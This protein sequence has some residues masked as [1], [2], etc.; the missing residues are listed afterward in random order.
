MKSLKIF[1]T[2]AVLAA[3]CVSG[4]ADAG[5]ARVF[6]GVGTPF[7]Y[8]VA[9]LPYYYYPPVVA[10]PAAPVTYVEQGQPSAG[11][12]QSSGSW[13]Y[14]DASRAYYPYV[15]QCPGGW[16]EVPTQPASSH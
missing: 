5:H 2:L 8:P 9:P 15:K 3:G 13:Y 14:C 4:S 6:V 16:R 7:F 10:V 1:V 11:P 12:R